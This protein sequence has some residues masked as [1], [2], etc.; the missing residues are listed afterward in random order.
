MD[1]YGF[2]CPYYIREQDLLPVACQSSCDGQRLAGT[3][4]GFTSRFV[5][6]SGFLNCRGREWKGGR[7]GAWCL[8]WPH[9]RAW[10]EDK[11]KAP[12][13]PPYHPLSLRNRGPFLHNL[14]SP[15]H[16]AG[17]QALTS[18]CRIITDSSLDSASYHTNRA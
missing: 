2:L 12:T 15:P 3:S 16:A 8:S 14:F 5:E 9:R 6:G 10:H 4:P 1:T 18:D 11:H 7:V 13:P 17:H